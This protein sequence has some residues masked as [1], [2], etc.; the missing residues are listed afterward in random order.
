MTRLK[1]RAFA[2]LTLV[3]AVAYVLLAYVDRSD[4]GIAFVMIAGA[5]FMLAISYAL[6]FKPQNLQLLP[7]AFT[8]RFIPLLFAVTLIALV[9]GILSIRVH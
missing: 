7:L 3:A 4:L 9:G 8:R 6:L 1:R 5:V 2:A